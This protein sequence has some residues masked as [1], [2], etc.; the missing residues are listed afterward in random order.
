MGEAVN[1]LLPEHLSLS[2]ACPQSQPW[3]VPSQ[4][5]QAQLFGG[6]AGGCEGEDRNGTCDHVWDSGG[7]ALWEDG[8]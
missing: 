8:V 7:L 2:C 1:P 5:H 6:P 3:P 4:G